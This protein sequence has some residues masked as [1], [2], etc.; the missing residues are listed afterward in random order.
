MPLGGEAER[1]TSRVPPH[2]R[3]L[4]LASVELALL[5]VA[6]PVEDEPDEVHVL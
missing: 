5:H 4:P 1:A 3:S 6:V 2:P